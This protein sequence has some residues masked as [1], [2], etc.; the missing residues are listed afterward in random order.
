M[1]LIGLFSCI[2][3]GEPPQVLDKMKLLAEKNLDQ[4][5]WDKIKERVNL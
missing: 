5:T 2:K 4:E 3:M 1:E